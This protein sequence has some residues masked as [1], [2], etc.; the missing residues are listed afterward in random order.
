M[1]SSANLA[2]KK[3][4]VGDGIRLLIVDDDADI[5]TSLVDLFQME[6]IA[7]EVLTARTEAQ[8]RQ[9]AETQ[10]ID[11]AL[12]DI[13]LGQQSGLDLVPLLKQR[14]RNIA[15]VM[16]TAY[17]DAKYAVNAIRFG[18]DDYLYKPLEPVHLLG[19]I[20]RFIKYQE[21]RKQRDRAESWFRTI[22][23]TSEQLLFVTDKTGQIGQINNAAS[24]F[25]NTEEKQAAGRKLW[26]LAPWSESERI[27]AKLRN[28]FMAAG[29]ENWAVAEVDTV[30]PDG[31]DAVVSFSIRPLPG[32]MDEEEY[33]LVEGRDITRTRQKENDL[34]VRVSHDELTRLPNRA[35]LMDRLRQLVSTGLRRRRELSVLFVDIDRFKQINDSHGHEIGDQVLKT[36]AAR[37][38]DCLREEDIV[39]R[40]SGDEFVVVLG[41]TNSQA[42]AESVAERIRSSIMETVSLD[43]DSIEISCSIGIA[44][45]PQHETDP[46]RLI[47]RADQAMYSAKK[48]GRNRYHTAD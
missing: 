1:K 4:E 22:F 21:F 42:K 14:N 43:D 12:L 37:I 44:L 23:E 39:A 15:C 48:Q 33:Y 5:V 25:C 10:P 20:R 41:E 16:M 29:P 8:A 34:L 13:R 31:K 19:T 40:Y 9:I 26:Q 2:E 7:G 47:S 17:R 38:S 32:K 28:A 45:F 18:A 3:K 30:G 27:A 24:I 11:I 35:H 6:G 36:I 46:E